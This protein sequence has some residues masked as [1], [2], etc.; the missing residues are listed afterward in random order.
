MAEEIEGAS[1]KKVE[2]DVEFGATAASSPRNR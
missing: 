2:L 1:A